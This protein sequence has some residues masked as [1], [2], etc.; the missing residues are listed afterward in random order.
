MTDLL[1]LILRYIWLAP[2]VGAGVV[3]YRLAGWRGVVAVATLG[4][5]WGL[6]R[7][8]RDDEKAKREHKDAKA[9]S[10]ALERRESV[11]NEIAKLNPDS[12]AKR[13]NPWLRDK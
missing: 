8:G 13:L 11:D 7:K 4:L 5:A 9:R 6:Y 12:R 2:L 1:D 10:E 3:A